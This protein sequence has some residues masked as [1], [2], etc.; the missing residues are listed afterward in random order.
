MS[1]ANGSAKPPAVRAVGTPVSVMVECTLQCRA[2]HGLASFTKSVLWPG[3]PVAGQ[4]VS[5]RELPWPVSFTAKVRE[6]I[7]DLDDVER[8]TVVLE[9]VSWDEILR[10]YASLPKSPGEPEDPQPGRSHFLDCIV[11]L[12]AGGWTL[13]DGRWF[14]TDE[15]KIETFTADGFADQEDVDG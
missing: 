3:V 6:T 5:Q 2:G 11:S 7:V 14:P 1:G 10:R 13:N 12:A 8:L 15:A 4:V 9:D